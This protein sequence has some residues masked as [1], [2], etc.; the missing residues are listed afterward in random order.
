MTSH[1]LSRHSSIHGNYRNHHE[2]INL[3]DMRLEI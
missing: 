3:K 2:E 1:F